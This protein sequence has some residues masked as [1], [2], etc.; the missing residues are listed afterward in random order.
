MLERQRYWW[1]LPFYEGK[2]REHFNLIELKSRNQILA[3]IFI[4][5]EYTYPLQYML[6]AK[7]CIKSWQAQTRKVNDK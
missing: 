4:T 3:S 1:K 2:M 6:A 5:K 7:Q